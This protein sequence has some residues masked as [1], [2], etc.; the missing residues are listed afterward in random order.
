MSESVFDYFNLQKDVLSRSFNKFIDD[1]Q[2]PVKEYLYHY[3][4]IDGLIGIFDKHKIWCSNIYFMNDKSEI[5]YSTDVVRTALDKKKDK[6][7]DQYFR[8]II[9][10]A[11][12]RIGFLRDIYIYILFVSLKMVIY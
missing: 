10:N 12:Y 11:S 1:I 7:G 5:E 3:T 8:K 2:G 4:N 9:E 6:I